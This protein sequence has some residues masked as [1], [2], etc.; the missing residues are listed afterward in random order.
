MGLLRI[1]GITPKKAIT[2]VGKPLSLSAQ[3]TEEEQIRLTVGEVMVEKSMDPI[4]PGSLFLEKG[5]KIWG[6]LLMR[7]NFILISWRLL[8]RSFSICPKS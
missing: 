6:K 4:K 5:L 3:I 1:Y 2:I 8:S 7:A